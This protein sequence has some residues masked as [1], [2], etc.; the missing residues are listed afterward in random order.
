MTQL[1]YEEQSLGTFLLVTLVLGGGAAWLTG[2]A[3]ARTWQSWRMV[4]LAGV[5]LGIGVRFA[6]FALFGATFAS[7]YYF[8]VDTLILLVFALG[9]YHATRRRQMAR[10][11]GFLRQL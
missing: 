8:A 6:H 5:P 4:V 9:G 10:Q 11:Y 7:P 2:R 1:L 3:L